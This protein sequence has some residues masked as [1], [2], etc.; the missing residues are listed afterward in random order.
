MTQTL[1]TLQNAINAQFDARREYEKSK[2]IDNLTIIKK[3][4]KLQNQMQNETVLQY[5][6]DLNIDATFINVHKSSAQRF[7]VYAVE[8]IVQFLNFLAERAHACD[9]YTLATLVNA[10]KLAKK[11]VEFS[12]DYQLATCSDKYNSENINARNLSQRVNV[13]TSTCSTQSSSTR[14]A[15]VALNLATVEKATQSA[16]KKLTVA[17]DNAH[18]QR[19]L[20]LIKSKKLN[21]NKV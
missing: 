9:K 15:L 2:N 8:K 14:C 20:D 3:F 10:D 1:Q 16:S 5:A 17:L 12:T 19:A 6:L 21:C 11:E 4:D 18:V 7:N 13:S